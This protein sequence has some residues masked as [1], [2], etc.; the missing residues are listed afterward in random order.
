MVLD[1]A[2]AAAMTG[3]ASMDAIAPAEGWRSYWSEIDRKRRD[4]A[5]SALS[6]AAPRV[7]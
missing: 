6:A 1:P 2:E 3:P 5:P 4:K 7:V